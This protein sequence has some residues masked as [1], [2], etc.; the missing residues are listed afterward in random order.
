M[1]YRAIIK[2]LY[3]KGL[4]GKEIYEG[5]VDDICYEDCPS[6]ATAKNWIACFKKEKFSIRDNERPGI[7]ISVTQFTPKKCTKAYS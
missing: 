3:L 1:K 2:Y 5:M 6:Y 7:L 4:R